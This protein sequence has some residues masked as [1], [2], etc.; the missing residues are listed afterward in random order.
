MVCN[1]ATAQRGSV[2]LTALATL[3]ALAL[4]A[5]GAF[6][7][8]GD[9]VLASAKRSVA[10]VPPAILDRPLRFTDLRW[11]LFTFRAKQKG[12]SFECSLD[13]SRFVRCPDRVVYGLIEGRASGK[14]RRCA[15]P[16]RNLRK[17]KHASKGRRHAARKRSRCARAKAHRAHR[18]ARL[19][20]RARKGRPTGPRSVVAC[21]QQAARRAR[22]ATH[23]GSAK[24]AGRKRGKRGKRAHA[25]LRRCTRAIILGAGKPLAFG[26]HTFRLRARLRGG[27]TSALATYTWTILTRAQLE[28]RER[29]AAPT[30][31][32]TAGGGSGSGAS[33]SGSTGGAPTGSGGGSG[34]GAGGGVGAGGESS[35]PIVRARSFEI[36]GSP[37]GTLFPGGPALTIPLKIFNPNPAPIIVVALQ[38]SVASS[39]P[40]CS[41]E[42]NLKILQSNISA[43]LPL[44]VASGEA[45]TLPAQGVS[46]PTIQF[47]N[48]PVN[49]DACQNA[50][51]PLI[52]SGSAST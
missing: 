23:K 24:R 2:G 32:P 46:A 4:S 21:A 5:G 30:G 15:A 29:A 18:G 25:H 43:T 19:G 22:K 40:G 20:R 33:G 13:R 9:H 26:N 49:Q 28:A 51:F 38:V 42:E 47:L 3:C 14:L 50:T 8:G 6:A 11:A 10:L 41:A 34:P 44:R 16:L 45:V 39:P 52:Y 31:R 12:A 37:E 36:S 35:A 17:G 27:G 48:L 1:R 7:L